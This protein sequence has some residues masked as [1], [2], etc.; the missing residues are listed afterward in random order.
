MRMRLADDTKLDAYF[1]AKGDE[2]SAVSLQVLQLADK[3]AADRTCALW[4]E[5]LEA[6]KELLLNA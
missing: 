5:R 3:E 2:K 4:T 1:T 6:L